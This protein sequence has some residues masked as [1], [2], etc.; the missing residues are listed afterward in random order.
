MKLINETSNSQLLAPGCLSLPI[1][2]QR[3]VKLNQ[4]LKWYETPIRCFYVS[5]T[6]L[7]GIQGQKQH[8][9]PKQ[10]GNQHLKL[11]RMLTLQS[12]FHRNWPAK[13]QGKALKSVSFKMFILPC[14]C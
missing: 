5:N 13:K 2:M 7:H 14:F 1:F 9:H 4:V 12:H 11:T 3:K 6:D 8:H 10:G